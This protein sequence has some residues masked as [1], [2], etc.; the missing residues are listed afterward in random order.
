MNSGVETLTCK[1]KTKT[2]E[3]MILKQ[4]YLLHLFEQYNERNEYDFNTIKTIHQDCIELQIK[5]FKK[6]NNEEPINKGDTD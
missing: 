2:D 3:E 1:F 4:E 5:V 6:E